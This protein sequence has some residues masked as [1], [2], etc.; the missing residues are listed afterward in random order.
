[1]ETPKTRK[2]VKIHT[3]P[4]KTYSEK[5]QVLK[6]SPQANV[7]DLNIYFSKIS[8]SLERILNFDQLPLYPV[9]FT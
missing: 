6:I 3:N 8:F 1:M 9:R 2:E 7:K 5:T 4:S